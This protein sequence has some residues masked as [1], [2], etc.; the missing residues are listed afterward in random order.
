MRLHEN[1]KLFTQSVRFT[2][3]QKGIKDIYIEKDYWVT[4][5]LYSIFNSEAAE[6]AV[7]KGGTALL[8]CFK[9]IERFSED[10]DMVVLN[11]GESGNQLKERLRK[12]S[13]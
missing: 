9:F 4:F 11:D 10:I 13:K 3:K 2:A 7:F 6:Y 12:L 5:A 1:E 8:K